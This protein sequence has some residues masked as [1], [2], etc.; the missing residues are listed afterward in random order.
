MF[1]VKENCQTQIDPSQ[2][3]M[4]ANRHDEA[5]ARSDGPKIDAAEDFGVAVA[6]EL[7]AV[8]DANSGL[9]TTVLFA[10]WFAASVVALAVKTM[11]EHC[12]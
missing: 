3:S 11:S 10:H 2:S 12:P 1:T 5:N 8:D 4:A 7:A 9:S 6:V